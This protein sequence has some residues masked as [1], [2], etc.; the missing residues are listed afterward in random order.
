MVGTPGEE[1][2]SSD[3]ANMVV[4]TIEF[5]PPESSAGIAAKFNHGYTIYVDN[6]G[7]GGATTRFWIDGPDDGEFVVGPRTGANNFAQIRLRHDKISGVAGVVLRQ[8]SSGVL[9]LTSSSRRYKRRI[10]D[11]A[12]DLDALRRLR[13][14]KFKD[15]SQI[16]DGARRIADETRG[17]GADIVEADVERATDE[18]EWYVGVIAEEVDELGLTELVTYEDDPDRPGERRPGGFR[19]ELV[20]LGALQLIQEQAGKMAKLEARLAKL[21]AQLGAAKTQGKG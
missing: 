1:I 15:R 14:V 7:S 8:D 2:A 19:Y 16:E 17:K 9:Y 4:E 18:G 12:M 20:A 21:E 6:T 3:F 11:H 13:V 10:T 5:D